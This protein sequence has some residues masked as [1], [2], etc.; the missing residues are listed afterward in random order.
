MTFRTTPT[1]LRRVRYGFAYGGVFAALMAFALASAPGSSAV[2]D[3]PDDAIVARVGKETITAGDL[4]RRIAAVPP[5]QL[6]S[7]GKTEDEIKQNFLERVLVR[8]LL[9][10]QGALDQKLDHDETIEDRVRATLRSAMVQQVRIETL[11]QPVTDAEVEKYYKDNAD[12][13]HSPERIAIWRI[14]VP[15]REDAEKVIAEMKKDASVKHWNDLARERS[16][17]KATHMRGGNLG[18]VEPDGKTADPSIVVDGAVL[19]AVKKLKDGEPAAEPVKEGEK[20]AVV[21][22]RQTMKAVERPLD[23]EAAGI[24]Q[25]IARQRTEEKLKAILDRATEERVKD[26]NADLVEEI[27]VSSQGDLQP[28]RRPGVLP[29]RRTAPG[30]PA[31]HNHR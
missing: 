19:D 13:F 3:S 10:S 11:A 8:D 21:W 24:R 15:T 16:V 6:R 2:A 27:T 22:R 25:T 4:R 12:K 18:Y 14:L 23:S 20:W 5:F 29:P 28:L 31:P 9:L 30:L 7:F 1:I 17:D 26:V